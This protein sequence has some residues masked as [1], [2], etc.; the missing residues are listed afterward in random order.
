MF[1][2]LIHLGFI[3]G[4]KELRKWSSLK[5]KFSFKIQWIQIPGYH[6]YNIVILTMRTFIILKIN[7]NKFHLFSNIHFYKRFDTYICMYVHACNKILFF[8][9]LCNVILQFD[10]TVTIKI[11]SPESFHFIFLN[12]FLLSWILKISFLL[13]CILL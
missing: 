11:F 4:Y 9:I 5:R 2:S 13:Y 8:T 1:R 12:I 10:I 7:S 6:L 3:L